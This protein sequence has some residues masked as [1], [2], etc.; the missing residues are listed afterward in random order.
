MADDTTPSNVP[1]VIK[2]MLQRFRLASD[3]EAENRKRGLAALRFRQGGREQWN[4][5]M[6]STRIDDNRPTESYN[7]IPQFVHQVTNDM[8]MNMPQTRFVPGS[9]GDEQT[10]EVYEDLVRNIQ[11]ATEAEVAYDAAAD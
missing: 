10:A 11:S 1:D 3:A 5:S 6:W 4:D 7:Q 8:S 9:D 2:R